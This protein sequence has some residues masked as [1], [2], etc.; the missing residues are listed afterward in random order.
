[1]CDLFDLTGRYALVVGAGSGIGLQLSKALARQGANVALLDIVG[2]SLASAAAQLAELG[3]DTYTHIVDVADPDSV[4]EAVAAVHRRFGRID[5]LVNSAGVAD[6]YNSEKLYDETWQKVM[7]INLNGTFYMCREV[8]KIMIEQ[9]YGKI[10]NIASGYSECVPPNWMWPLAP[11]CTSK[12]GVKMLTK[13]LAVEWA[14]CGITVNAIGPGYFKTG[15]T[16]T[17]I[18]NERMTEYINVMNPMGRYGREGELDGVCIL[19]ASD[20]SSYLTGELIRVD[21]GTCCI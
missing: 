2:E 21:G 9:H 13:E 11:Y 3:V 10:I 5:I 17:S 20:A 19:L 14:K 16:H 8:G 4:R 18:D 7:D 6:S 12:G 15:L 1:M